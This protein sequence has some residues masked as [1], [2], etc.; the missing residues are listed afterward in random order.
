MSWYIMSTPGYETFTD[1][2][3]SLK[4]KGTSYILFTRRESGAIT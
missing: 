3:Q 4:E 1:E 2:Q